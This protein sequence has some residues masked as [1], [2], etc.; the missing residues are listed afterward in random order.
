VS[1]TGS[2]AFGRDGHG[3]VARAG[4]WGSAAGDPGS[5]YAIGRAALAAMTRALDDIGPPTIL[6]RL[7][8][9][10]KETPGPEYFRPGA[11]PAEIAALAH[12]VVEAAAAGDPSAA[13][14]LAQAGADLADQAVAVATRLSLSSPIPTALGGGV[15]VHVRAVADALVATAQRAGVRLSP[16]I[17]ES[18]VIGALRLARQP[19]RAGVRP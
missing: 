14:I 11:A 13:A 5:G 4:G 17:V 19:Q 1:G 16:T 8:A 18:P 7:L 15:L 10:R 2:I 9:D 6:S 3:R 12:L